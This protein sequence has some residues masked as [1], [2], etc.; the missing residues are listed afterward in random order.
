MMIYEWHPFTVYSPPKFNSSPLKNGDWKTIFL[1]RVSGTFLRGELWKTSGGHLG[2]RSTWLVPLNGRLLRYYL[3]T[4]KVQ[5]RRPACDSPTTT[6]FRHPSKTFRQP[7]SYGSNMPQCYHVAQAYVPSFWM[8]HP[9]AK[10]IAPWKK[11]SFLLTFVFSN[12]SKK[13]TQKKNNSPQNKSIHIPPNKKQ[14]HPR[15]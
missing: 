14:I 4:K 9:L 12:L 15:R 10:S 5:Q 7:L 2:I 8:H 1:L 3:L 13:K 11:T 6:V